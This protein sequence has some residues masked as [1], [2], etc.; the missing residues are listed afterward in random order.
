MYFLHCSLHQRL[1]VI[2][3]NGSLRQ[4][5]QYMAQV[6]FLRLSPACP[7]RPLRI[8]FS[9]ASACALVEV[10][11]QLSIGCQ[12]TAEIESIC[13]GFTAKV[14]LE[15]VGRVLRAH[16][17][18]LFQDRCRIRDKATPLV[19]L[20]HEHLIAISASEDV[21]RVGFALMDVIPQKA[22]AA[23]HKRTFQT[24]DVLECLAAM[25]ALVVVRRVRQA[26]ALMF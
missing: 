5:T 25:L 7:S 4:A 9:P 10:P 19:K 1:V 3:V 17:R 11:H 15:L 8:S 20:I 13:E 26:N 2:A 24:V 18:M 22:C 6:C 16:F 12:T 14:A 23:G 21:R